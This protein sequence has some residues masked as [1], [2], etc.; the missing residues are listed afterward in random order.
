M[1]IMCTSGVNNNKILTSK[2][3]KPTITNPNANMAKKNIDLNIFSAV[4]G[5][6]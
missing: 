4:F 6:I 2:R 3:N 5:C 1:P